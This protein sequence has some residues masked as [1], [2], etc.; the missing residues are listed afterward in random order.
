MGQNM[1]HDKN[2]AKGVLPVAR[3]EP[4]AIGLAAILQLPT[5]KGANGRRSIV[6][7]LLAFGGCQF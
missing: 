7:V 5:N 1:A 6:S 3:Q 4:H 2:K